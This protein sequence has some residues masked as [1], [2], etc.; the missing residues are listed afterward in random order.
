[1]ANSNGLVVTG[2]TS[3]SPVN[4]KLEG[5]TLSTIQMT[6]T[7]QGNA[8]KLVNFIVALNNV[9][10]TSTVKLV[11][12]TVPAPVTRNSTTSGPVTGDNTTSG[13]IAGDNTTAGAPVTG[14]N[15]TGG[16][17]ITPIHVVGENA[18]AKIEMAVYSYRGE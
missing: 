12:I 14:D 17:V 11:E 6:A 13:P 3:T 15:T 5:V 8:D 1:M 4:Q 10:K 18:T 16:L 9:L 2:M 7:V